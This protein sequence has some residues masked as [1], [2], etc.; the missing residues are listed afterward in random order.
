VFDGHFGGGFKVRVGDLAELGYLGHAVV[1][2]RRI[3]ACR[4]SVG[5]A[6][7]LAAA[8]FQAA[9]GVSSKSLPEGRLRGVAD[10][11]SPRSDYW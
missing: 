3:V 9:F 11:I 4:F 10:V 2:K 6:A 7:N 1:G 8:A 5:R